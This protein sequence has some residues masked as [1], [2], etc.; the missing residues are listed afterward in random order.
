MGNTHDLSRSEKELLTTLGR[1]PHLSMKELVNRTPYKWASTIVKRLEE[2]RKQRTLWGPVYDVDYGKLCKNPLHKVFC[3]IES[4]R[5][6]TTIMSYLTLITSLT[7]G[8]FVLSPQKN[9][10]NVGFFSSNDEKLKGLLQLLKDNNIIANYTFRVYGS[11]RIIENPNFFGDIN[12]S[13]DNVVDPCDVPDLS[14][15]CHDTEW[16]E[17]DLAVLPYLGAG[18]KGGKLIEILRAE[19]RM[20]RTWTYTQ[21]NYSFKKMLNNGLIEKKY[22]IYP[23]ETTENSVF[24]LFLK[25]E[26]KEMAQ[27]ILCN[28]ARGARVCRRYAF[29]GGW[30][31]IH[32]M[33]HPM[34][35]ADLMY[36]LDSIEE[37]K[38]K[39]IY[40]LRSLRGNSP[41]FLPPDVKNYD[42]D[43]QTLEYPYEV[44]EEKIKE[45]LESEG[46]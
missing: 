43:S 35:L 36:N 26:D 20:D 37:I 39:E 28:F 10:L 27:R 15:G 24:N 14:L 4:G 5:K 44:C 30:G 46:R 41:L 31:M 7:W 42:F 6:N 18:Y 9:V 34:F 21:V 3:I 13:L 19:K 22:I 32:C 33:C 12:P 8:I 1:Y 38:A 40:H 23:F 11:R 17:C 29:F 2:F 45:K 16:N 25:I